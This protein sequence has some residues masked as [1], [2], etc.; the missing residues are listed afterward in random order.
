MTVALAVRNPH[1]EHFPHDAG[2]SIRGF[3]TSAAE[4]FS[5]AGKALT[6]I[7]TDAVVESRSA[8]EVHC[9]APDLG[10]LLVDFLNTVIYEM[11]LRDMLFGRFNIRIDG[12]TLD[13]TIWGEPVDVTRH[14]PASEPKGASCT[15]L[16]VARDGGNWSAACMIDL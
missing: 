14:K 12:N 7:F 4:A 8:V 3:G 1:R 15:A 16:G 5:Q 2:I 13:A 11:A 9:E 10:L 6:A